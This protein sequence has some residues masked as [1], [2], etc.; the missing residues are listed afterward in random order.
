[1]SAPLQAA[2]RHRVS[3]PAWLI[4]LVVAAAIAVAGIAVLADSGASVSAQT[5]PPLSPHTS[6]TNSVAGHC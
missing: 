5:T 2:I 4:A 1:M 6:C 3:V